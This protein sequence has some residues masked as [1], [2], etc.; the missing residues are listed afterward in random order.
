MRLKLLYHAN[1]FDGAASAAILSRFLEGRERL[2]E[3][4]FA[5]VQHQ[6]GSP[7]GPDAFDGDLNAIVD[8]RFSPSPRL[9]WW[10]DHHQ[11]AFQ[12]AADRAA[13]EADRSGTKFWDPA[14]PSNTG[15][16]TRVL[17]ERFGWRA[18][19]LEELVSW[20][21][22][23][24]A[25]R[26]PSARVAVRL[27]EPA[28]R[29]MA[30]LEASQDPAFPTR[31]IRAFQ[32]ETLA[33]IAAAPWVAGPLVPVL[34]RHARAVDSYRALARLERGVVEADLSE[35]GVETPNKF[36]PYDL[37]PAARYAVAVTREAKRAKIA[38]G[39]NP[40]APAPRTHDIARICERYG[41]GGHPVVGAVSLAPERLLDAR[42]IARE[43]AETLRGPAAE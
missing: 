21:D 23:I 38:V 3:T 41:G 27:E 32:G 15:F 28:L 26:F 17:A 16:M 36:I 20:A 11:S 25:A 31:L 37:F 8:F 22:V 35:A 2:S 13:F 34:E 14:A 9:H 39:S 40:W 24:D 4:A 33:A 18:P 5:P 42:R 6:E 43:I 10:F 30:V 12:P 19:D 29:I 7:F 1:C